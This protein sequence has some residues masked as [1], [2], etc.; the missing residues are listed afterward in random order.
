MTRFWTLVLSL[1]TLRTAFALGFTPSVLA[2][3]P[4]THTSKTEL[5]GWFDFKPVHGG[6]SANEETLD[7][8]WEAQ[9][10]ILRKRR[11]EGGTKESLKKKYAP[12][13]EVVSEEKPA[14]S[15]PARETKDEMYVQ[16]DT[17]KP[18]FMKMPWEK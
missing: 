17:S 3:R 13:K 12:K 5:A 7:E 14:S 6:G 18:F 15:A 9:Q 8:I 10:E 2:T 16:E 1:L 11:G 4:F